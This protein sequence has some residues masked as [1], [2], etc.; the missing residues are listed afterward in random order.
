MR[1]LNFEPLYSRRSTV[2]NLPGFEP[3]LVD[4]A[5]L[6]NLGVTVEP[7]EET[8]KALESG[9]DVFRRRYAEGLLIPRQRYGLAELDP[10]AVTPEIHNYTGRCPALTWEI[11][12][13]RGCT[14]GCQYCLVSDG[15]H[16]QELLAYENYHLYVRRLL[17]EQNGPGS[18][19]ERHY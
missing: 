6:E 18:P 9:S 4:K 11:N 2:Y 1:V 12:P 7:S 19:N 5:Y 14:V 13:V 8:L 3:R 15:V 16:E 10:A 17:D